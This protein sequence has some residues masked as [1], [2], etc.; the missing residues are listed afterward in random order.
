MSCFLIL[1][2]LMAIEYCMFRMYCPQVLFETHNK[3]IP[4]LTTLNIALSSL[5]SFLY[6]LKFRVIRANGLYCDRC[7]YDLEDIH[8]GRC[9]KCDGR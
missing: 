8:D 9:P 1:S 4:L 2:V 5:L 6:A 7:G 3:S